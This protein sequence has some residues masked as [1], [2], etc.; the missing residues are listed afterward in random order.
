MGQTTNYFSL[1]QNSSP[2]SCD[3][4]TSLSESGPPRALRRLFVTLPVG[5]R[6]TKVDKFGCPRVLNLDFFRHVFW[7]WVCCLWIKTGLPKPRRFSY[8]S[9]HIYASSNMNSDTRQ[10][11][12]SLWTRCDSSAGQQRS[13]EKTWVPDF[14]YTTLHHP[15][16]SPMTECYSQRYL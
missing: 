15:T 9:T 4:W 5:W 1:L 13:N 11:T 7:F 10:H 14:T 3:S 6:A 16:S 2:G 8:Q 12:G